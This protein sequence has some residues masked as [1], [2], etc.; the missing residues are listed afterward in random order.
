MANCNRVSAITHP[1]PACVNKQQW[2]STRTC[3]C[4]QAAGDAQH[5]LAVPWCARA[6]VAIMQ[7]QVQG[8]A[9]RSQ[10]LEKVR[11]RCLLVQHACS[12]ALALSSCICPLSW[13]LS[14]ARLMI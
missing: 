11:W 14:Q 2:C 8:L 6:Q 12:S 1:A 9:V 10:Q 7:L 4:P 5:A 3:M 13:L